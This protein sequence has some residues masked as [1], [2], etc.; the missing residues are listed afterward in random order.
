MKM[1]EI[2]LKYTPLLVAV[3]GGMFALYQWSKSNSLKKARFLNSFIEKIR[4]DK[5]IVEILRYLDLND[6]WYSIE[7]HDSDDE[8]RQR[9]EQKMDKTLS[10]FSYI[11]YLREKRIIT[12]KE[13]NFFN[14]HIKLILKNPGIQDYFYHLYHYVTG[15]F[16]AKFQ[17][18]H[19]LDYGA[20][21]HIIDSDFFNPNAHL[22]NNKYTAHFDSWYA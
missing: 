16:Q 17:Q 13:F 1:L 7:F 5:D 15:K 19:L 21:T 14:W 9:F 20:K 8:S 10:Y 3:V 4:G 22:R 6:S 11:C 12:D 18:Q 2:C